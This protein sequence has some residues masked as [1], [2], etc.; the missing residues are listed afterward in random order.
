MLKHDWKL[1]E[2][3]ELG[4]G[5]KY[6]YRF[7]VVLTTFEMVVAQP[8]P[9]ARVRWTHLIVDEGHRLK[10]RHS[11]VLDELRDVRSRR[12]LVLTGTPLQNHVAELW[13]IPSSL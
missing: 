10:N 7:N 11:R 2:P 6:K 13:P 3:R 9:L 5:K 12:K 1:L 8:E 4:D